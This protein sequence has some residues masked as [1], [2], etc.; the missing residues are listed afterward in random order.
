MTKPLEDLAALVN[1]SI[2]LV[3]PLAFLVFGSCV[4]D[5]ESQYSV[6]VRATDPAPMSKAVERL[7]MLGPVGVVLLP[8]AAIAAWRTWILA[9]RWPQERG[10][11]GV[12]EAGLCGVGTALL[13]LAPGIVTRPMEAPG[14]VLVYGG[15]ALIVGLVV[16]L[17]LRAT[18]VAVLRF[19]EV[20]RRANEPH[21]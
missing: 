12:A 21:G 11:Q 17:I 3:V 20:R 10:W 14:F 4:F 7:L 13:Y 16:G 19:P 1:G 18:A 2:V 5:S 6:T 9:K 15:A 8:F